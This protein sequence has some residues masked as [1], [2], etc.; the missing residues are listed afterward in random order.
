MSTPAQIFLGGAAGLTTWRDEIAIPALTAAGVSY[1]NPQL[2]IHAWTADR[3]AVEMAA[4]DAATVLLFVVSD[5]TRGVATVAEIAYYMGLGRSLALA[6]VDLPAGASLYGQPRP[7]EE[8]DD[9]NRGRLF[10]RTM[11]R[12]HNVPVFP[13]VAEAVRH[14][15][16]LACPRQTLVS[17][18]QILADVNF[19]GLSFSVTPAGEHFLLQIRTREFEGR[20][21]H[22]DAAATRADVVR[23]ALKATLT[24]QE[25]ETREFFTYRGRRVHGPHFEV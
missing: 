6:I 4:K 12:R 1:F 13:T 23:T 2:P 22:I 15:I 11:A 20:Q 18:R 14:A 24:W 5:E 7:M 17:L 8:I 25:H 16:A 10:V 9:L 19:P 3:E 21:W